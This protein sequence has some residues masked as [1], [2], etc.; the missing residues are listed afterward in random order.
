[1]QDLTQ[2]ENSPKNPAQTFL[3]VGC[4]LRPGFNN[5]VCPQGLTL[6]LGVDFAPKNR[7]ANREFH[8]Q[9]V[10]SPIG[11]KVH[12]GGKV[13]NGPLG[14][15][16]QSF[17]FSSLSHSGPIAGKLCERYIFMALRKRGRHHEPLLRLHVMY[18]SSTVKIY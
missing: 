14:S 5:M 12:S 6:P 13:K 4:N 8:P 11:D 18:T 1:L 7:G 9:G 2:R 10:T 15:F 16:S 17:I 3:R